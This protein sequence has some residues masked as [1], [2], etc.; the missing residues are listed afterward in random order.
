M[1]IGG[2]LLPPIAHIDIIQLFQSTYPVRLGVALARP[3]ASE[4]GRGF[5]MPYCKF[6][7]ESGWH[8]RFLI[9]ETDRTF[10]QVTNGALKRL[11]C[12]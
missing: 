2:L 6:D 3:D 10:R 11:S 12:P 5:S 9:V 8:D 4:M 7:L 1:L